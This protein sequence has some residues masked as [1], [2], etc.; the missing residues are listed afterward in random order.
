MATVDQTK[1]TGAGTEDNPLTDIQIEDLAKRGITE[2]DEVAGK[3]I[4]TPKGTFK[5]ISNST[6]IGDPAATL[7]AIKK[8]AL[9]IQGKLTTLREQEQSTDSGKLFSSSTSER[10]SEKEISNTIDR[11]QSENE[12]E[13]TPES[14]FTRLIDE[15]IK[16]LDANFKE[17]QR[18]IKETFKQTESKLKEEQRRESS[19]LN[20]TLQRIGGFMGQAASTTGAMLNLAQ[21]HK[22]EIAALATAKSEALLSARRARDEN[23][24]KL[25]QAKANEVRRI[26]QDI[27]DRQK[28]F[29][30]QMDQ[31]NEQLR[32]DKK[33]AQ[34]EENRIRDDARQAVNTVLS[35]FG[36]LPL[37]LLDEESLLTLQDM[38]EVAGIPAGFL[39]QVATQAEQK[40]ASLEQQ[41]E[42]SN[43]LQGAGLFIRE[44]SLAISQARL[45]E[46]QSINAL[47]AQRLGLPRSL[48]G[49]RESVITEQMRQDEPPEWFIE[50]NEQNAATGGNVQDWASFVNEVVEDDDV[51]FGLNALPAPVL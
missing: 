21:Q 28:E 2:G 30:R 20:T 8:R 31:L 33:D 23:A 11:I 49:V 44:Q 24:F 35:T 48:I 26:E 13:D 1:R 42:I 5:P 40:Q 27:F 14:E 3:G 6:S 47:D 10:T 22:S 17:E 43:A 45:A 32:Q 51:L 37:Q 4:L 34:A 38:A 50:M 29:A 18:V 16:Q 15:Q 9:E 41:R 19:F 25:A 12:R 7:E 46:D 36:S 39:G